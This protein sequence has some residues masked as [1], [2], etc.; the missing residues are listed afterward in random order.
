MFMEFLGDIE[1]FHDR[2][3]PSGMGDISFHQM[4]Y[5]V[6][7]TISTIGY[8]DFSPK[9]ILGRSFSSP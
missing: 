2:F 9:T 5:F 6:T 7:V 1:S 8:G 3:L 4:C